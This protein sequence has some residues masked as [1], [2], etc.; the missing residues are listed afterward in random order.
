MALKVKPTPNTAHLVERWLD[1]LTP[2]AR[3]EAIG[4]LSRPDM[5]G[6]VSLTEA[7]RHDGFH[8]TEGAI[9]GWRRRNL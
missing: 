5:Y 1:T 3:E 6:P 2:S 4:Y 8:G 9:Q 7:F